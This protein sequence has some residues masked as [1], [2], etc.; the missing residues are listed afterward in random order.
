MKNI[1]QFLLSHSIFISFCAVALCYQTFLLGKIPVNYTV[2]FFVFF[3]TLSS[4]NFYWLLSKFSFRKKQA[5][6]DFLINNISYILL[7]LIASAGMVVSFFFI[8][9]YFLPIVFSILF[10][11]LYSLPL[12]PF[13]Q[14]R[15][16]KKPGFLKTTLLAFTWAVVTV[17]LPGWLQ[18]F[19]NSSIFLIFA[20]RSSFMLFLCILFDKR[21]AVI[22]KIHKLNSLATD[23]SAKQLDTITLASFLLFFIVGGSVTLWQTNFIH[24]IF[25]SLLALCM[26][27]VNKAS[28][29][30]TGSYIFYYFIVDGLMLLCAI[31]SFLAERV[32]F[33]LK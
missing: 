4:Y 30:Y 24:L 19:S 23:L 14:T 21:D 22:D 2:Y 27:I 31:Q 5:I 7:F 20:A 33:L 28:A 18:L 15:K 32:T 11:L 10:T 13:P 12:W 9:E 29:R 25:F 8:Q 26:I 16:I 17:I 1:L 6:T 3:A